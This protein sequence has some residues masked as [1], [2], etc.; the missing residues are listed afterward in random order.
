M[1]GAV[2]AVAVPAPA[3]AV[4]CNLS[5]F[6]VWD[7][8]DDCLQQF[9]WEIIGS[10]GFI[11][12]NPQFVPVQNP[13]PPPPTP[14]QRTRAEIFRTVRDRAQYVLD[15]FDSCNGHISKFE[16]SQARDALRNAVIINSPIPDMQVPNTVATYDANAVVFPG[17]QKGV[18]TLFPSFYESSASTLWSIFGTYQLDQNP[19]LDELRVVALLH[20][21]G[22]ITEVNNHPVNDPGADFN[23]GILRECIGITATKPGLQPEAPTQ[24]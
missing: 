9:I 22:H 8:S 23:V 21:V 2:Q 24:N 10:C 17:G 1:L 13:P 14:V 15:S 7:T 4:S 6:A 18:I 16:G 3:E 20:E 12:P 11:D 5:A 19:T